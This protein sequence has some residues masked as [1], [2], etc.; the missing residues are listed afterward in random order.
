MLPAVELGTAEML[1]TVV[2]LEYR[3]EQ[4]ENALGRNKERQNQNS[5]KIAL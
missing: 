1:E 2:M 3:V 5:E 4:T